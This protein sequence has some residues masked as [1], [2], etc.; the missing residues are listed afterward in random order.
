MAPNY[1]EP[2]HKKRK[3][4]LEDDYDISEIDQEEHDD[5][6]EEFRASPTRKSRR[7]KKPRS[8]TRDH[9]SSSE[10]GTMVSRRV[11]TGTSGHRLTSSRKV[12]AE[13]R[14]KDQR[15]EAGPSNR[16][17]SMEGSSKSGSS[18]IVKGKAR[19]MVAETPQKERN[20]DFPPT[21]FDME[22][23]SEE[24]MGDEEATEKTLSWTSDDEKHLQ[25]TNANEQSLINKTQK[26]FR[27]M[28]YDLIPANNMPNQEGDIPVFPAPL[29]GAFSKLVTCPAFI[30]RPEFFTYCLQTAIHERAGKSV[31]KKP[32]LSD[33]RTNRLD[34]LYASVEKRIENSGEQKILL[35]AKLKTALADAVN[36][37]F[38]EDLPP[39]IAFIDEISKLKRN[40]PRGRHGHQEGGLSPEIIKGDFDAIISSWDTYAKDKHLPS[41]EQSNRDFP[42][43]GGPNKAGLPSR[44]ELTLL[45]KKEWVL[46]RRKTRR[47]AHRR[48]SPTDDTDD[49]LPGPSTTKVSKTP[50]RS[51]KNRDD[52]GDGT[53]DMG[54]D[55]SGIQDEALEDNTTVS[56]T[57]GKTPDDVLTLTEVQKTPDDIL[58]L[59]EM[60]KTPDD[61]LASV[62]VQETPD[63]ALA[64]VGGQETPDDALASAEGGKT[65]AL[66]GPGDERT[67]GK[68]LASGPATDGS[69]FMIRSRSPSPESNLLSWLNLLDP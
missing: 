17:S 33:I 3:A 45:S 24:E 14:S 53:V 21:L 44:K 11:P 34:K 10:D 13:S 46:N 65:F 51:S 31:Q 69:S 9:D 61:A 42:K 16:R 39:H 27:Q 1:S 64:S 41:I 48:P 19:A 66:T 59:T 58:T 6:D 4:P 29:A 49:V 55:N 5:E 54:V 50:G 22:Q 35:S 12:E 7:T 40:L 68:V 32:K 38:G 63:G 57:A 20:R 36:E 30:N 47:G 37:V 60:Q 67:S 8:S 25:L 15:Q 62:G 2:P 52:E 43:P 28:P 23:G 56:A 26:L 18:K